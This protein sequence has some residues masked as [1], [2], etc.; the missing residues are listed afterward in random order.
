MASGTTGF[1][2][3]LVIGLNRV[4]FGTFLADPLLVIAVFPSEVLLDPNQVT[5]GVAGIMMEA[6]GLRAHEHALPHHGRLSLQ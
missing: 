6:A 5:E 1:E 3:S 2:M 4:A